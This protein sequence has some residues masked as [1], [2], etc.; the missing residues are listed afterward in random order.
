MEKKITKRTIINAML[1]E[2]A[3]KANEDYVAYLL[4]ELELMDNKSA[5]KKEKDEKKKAEDGKLLAPIMDKFEEGFKG[6]ISE[7]LIAIPS[8]Q[9]ISNQKVT[10]LLKPLVED[11]TLVKNQNGKR[12]EYSLATEDEVAEVNE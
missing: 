1:N 4:H 8:L 5:N 7:I 11:G 6:T 12:M 2:E 3:I 9:G 10:S